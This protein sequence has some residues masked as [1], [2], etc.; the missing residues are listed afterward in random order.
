MSNAANP[1]VR[2]N[3]ACGS[4]TAHHVALRRCRPRVYVA[5]Q[6][7]K[8]RESRWVSSRVLKEFAAKNIWK[9]MMQA[10]KTKTIKTMTTGEDSET[11]A[12]RKQE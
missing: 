12:A 11:K 6:L 8:K 2:Q 4:G 9:L 10:A 7:V 3:A 5:P 1:S